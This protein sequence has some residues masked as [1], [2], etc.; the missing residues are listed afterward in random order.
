MLHFLVNGK[1]RQSYRSLLTSLVKLNGYVII[2][3]C[4]LKGARQCSGLDVFR[5]DEKI[6]TEF[7]SDDFTL[8]EYFDYLYQMP[9][10]ETRP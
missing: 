7:L 2:A 1:E 3:A 10:G 5:Y 4:S 9:S 8:I 6:A